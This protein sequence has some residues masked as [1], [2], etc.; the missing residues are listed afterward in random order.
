MANKGDWGFFCV[1]DPFARVSILDD[2]KMEEIWKL[3]TP[4]ALCRIFTNMAP[5]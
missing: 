5:R 2:P 4:N 3:V 1:S